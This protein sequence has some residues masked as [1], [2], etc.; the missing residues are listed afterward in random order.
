MVFLIAHL[1]T[2]RT[3]FFR[4]ILIA[5]VEDSAMYLNQDRLKIFASNCVTKSSGLVGEREIMKL[6]NF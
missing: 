3:G 5:G 2:L 1:H 6:S 4:K